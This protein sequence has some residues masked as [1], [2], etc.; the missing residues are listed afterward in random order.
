VE[1]ELLP[2]PRKALFPTRARHKRRFCLCSPTTAYS[3]R[4]II[5][6]LLY[7]Y[8]KNLPACQELFFSPYPVLA[9]LF[10]QDSLVYH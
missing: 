7:Y 9:I 2:R 8:I 4:K 3:F 10:L 5:K 6:I 1:V